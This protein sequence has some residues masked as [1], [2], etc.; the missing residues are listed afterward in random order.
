MFKYGLWDNDGVLYRFTSPLRLSFRMAAYDAIR[1]IVDPELSDQQAED[2]LKVSRQEYGDS[3]AELIAQGY[4][5]A[6]LNLSHHAALDHTLIECDVQVRDAFKASV[7]QGM[8]HGILTHGVSEWC[9]R[10]LN[11][12]ELSAFINEKRRLTAEIMDYAKKHSGVPVFN[13]AL[14]ILGFPVDQTFFVEDSA[15]NLKPAH[16][17]GLYTVLLHRGTPLE[18]LPDYIDHQCNGAFDVFEHIQILN[19]EMSI[20]MKRG[21]SSGLDYTA[22][23]KAAIS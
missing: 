7:E 21:L 16:E 8:I 19:S 3:F 1:E 23:R 15:K 14:D 11:Q 13:K 4:S 2:L 18:N 17:A 10:T 22:T 12:T 5:Q 20:E 6:A 9:D